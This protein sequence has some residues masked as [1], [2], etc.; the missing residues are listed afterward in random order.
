MGNIIAKAIYDTYTENVSGKEGLTG[1][2]EF[3]PASI[4]TSEVT[5][6]ND[7]WYPGTTVS[8][9]VAETLTGHVENAYI[10]THTIQLSPTEYIYMGSKMGMTERTKYKNDYPE[11][12]SEIDEDVVP[13]YYCTKAGLYGGNY[14]EAGKN[15][16]GLEAWSSMLE[17]DRNMFTFNYDALDLL[18]DPASMTHM[19]PHWLELKPTL[20]TIRW[21][22]LLTIQHPI[23]R[24]HLLQSCLSV[25]AS[26]SSATGLQQP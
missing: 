23:L 5:I 21:N 10:C 13:A 8:A 9:S 15:Y 2:A 11:L 1:Q 24:K 4:V 7:T 6:G 14:Y 3:G 20:P 12:A 19:M 22:N 26:P 16:R 25:P 18:I 17:T